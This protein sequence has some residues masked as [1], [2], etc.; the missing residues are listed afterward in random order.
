MM[1]RIVDYVVGASFLE[2]L[3]ERL[4]E[5]VSTKPIGVLVAHNGNRFDIPFLTRHLELNNLQLPNNVRF[6]L[7]ML[8]LACCVI[9][10]EFST[11]HNLFHLQ[12]ISW[13]HCTTIAQRGL[14]LLL[15]TMPMLTSMLL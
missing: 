10:S 11:Q 3:E 1:Y 12:I 8:E 5:S 4:E 2:F 7:D 9:R 13:Q 14:C 6:K 15:H